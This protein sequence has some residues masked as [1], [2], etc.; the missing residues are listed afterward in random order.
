MR[1]CVCVCV[2]QEVASARDHAGKEGYALHRFP[3]SIVKTPLPV[4][5]QKRLQKST[6]FLCKIRLNEAQE[7]TYVLSKSKQRGRMCPC[8]SVC[9]RMCV[10]VSVCLSV[11]RM[12]K[13]GTH[14]VL[15]FPFFVSSFF[16]FLGLSTSFQLSA[17]WT[18]FRFPKSY[19]LV[20]F[21]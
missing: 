12:V 21:G 20:S 11:W 13:A 9:V 6:F 19:V 5:I 18:L 17:V 2:K 3:P 14:S 4:H 16:F 15:P 10:C 8:V 1:V 7:S